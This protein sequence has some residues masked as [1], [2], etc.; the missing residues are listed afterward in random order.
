MNMKL[1]RTKF[2]ISLVLIAILVLP[3]FGNSFLHNVQAGYS[4]EKDT[5]SD[6]RAGVAAAHTFVFTPSVTTAFTSI[7]FTF[8]TTASGTCTAPTGMI[9][10]AVPTLAAVGTSGISGASAWSAAGSSA[11]CTGS[12]NTNCN[13]VVTVTGGTTQSL[14]A[15][16]VGVSGGITNP[17]T[18]NTTYYVRISSNTA[19]TGTVAFGILD[20]TSIT[21]S[22]TVDPTFSFSIAGVS[23]GQ[24]VNS[25]TTTETT[26]STTVPFSASASIGTT[27][28]IAAHDLTVS[29]NGSGG[30]TISV[31]STTTNPLTS[32]SNFF[33]TFTGT[34]G[35]PTTW[36]APAGAANSSSGYFGYT[37]G[38][39]NA[40]S[41]FASNKWAGPTTTAAV[42]ASKSS[43]ASADVTRVGWQ[44]QANAFQPPGA[45]TGVELLVAT[46]TY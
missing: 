17:S 39:T 38:G 13:I 22:A 26:T 31:A 8:C 32:G 25:A 23:S 6:S 16:T 1:I 37:S 5:I 30:Y 44:I 20:T 15:V 18:V 41:Q 40:S 36:S 28:H 4:S 24:T 19:D 9:L 33:N 46:P 3:P 14:S 27:A 12:G 43:A 34:N 2:I 45:Y 10:T 35:S 29:T 21:V 7:T 11:T 42:I